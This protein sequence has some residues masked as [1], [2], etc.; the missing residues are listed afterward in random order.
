MPKPCDHT[1]VGIIIRNPAGHIAVIKR[2]NFPVAY[3]LPAGHCD[4]DDPIQAAKREAREEVNVGIEDERLVLTEEFGN[5]CR[6]ERGTH[7]AWWVFEPK[8]CDIGAAE[9]GSDAKEL[10]WLPES[11]IA[12]LANR[13]WLIAKKYGFR[14]FSSHAALVDLLTADPE[15]KAYLGLELV[16]CIILTRI[17]MVRVASSG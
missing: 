13:T 5:P 12:S 11:D 15:W 16:W 1:S 6:R 10:I 4:G 3:A 17:K 8:E 9:P 14:G 2:K 7:H